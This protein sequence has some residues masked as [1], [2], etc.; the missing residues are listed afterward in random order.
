MGPYVLI[1][2]LRSVEF[3]DFR[4]FLPLDSPKSSTWPSLSHMFPMTFRDVSFSDCSHSHN[5]ISDTDTY[6]TTLFA[7]DAIQ[8]IF[9]YVIQFTLSS[10]PPPLPLSPQVTLVGVYPLKIAHSGRL[11]A[12]T[13]MES[14]TMS[15]ITT[16]VVYPPSFNLSLDV[17]LSPFHQSRNTSEGN[18]RGFVSAHT[19]G[20]QGK[21][22]IWI[23]RKRSNTVREVQVWS[24]Q[25][26]LG[27]LNSVS[28]IP[29]RTV[30]SV[31]SHDLRGA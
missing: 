3:H 14:T 7:Y 15:S 10:E 29:Q 23:E 4:S 28:Q 20:R 6:T 19:I 31:N 9:Q 24:K 30:Y 16:P 13:S 5:R 1:F 21:R 22:A 11:A 25:P 27:D 12:P 2:R 26:T 17:T 8:G 18:T